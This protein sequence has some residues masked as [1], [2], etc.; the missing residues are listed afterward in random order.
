MTLHE[1]HASDRNIV[2]VDA[3]DDDNFYLH[4]DTFNSDCEYQDENGIDRSNNNN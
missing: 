3:S 2:N 4:N 1:L